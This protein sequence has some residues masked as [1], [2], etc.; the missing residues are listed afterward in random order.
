MKK[1]NID[2]VQMVRDIRDNIYNEHKA[3]GVRLSAI[4]L[5]QEARDTDLWKRLNK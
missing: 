4:I 5:S 1:S 2:C 3:K